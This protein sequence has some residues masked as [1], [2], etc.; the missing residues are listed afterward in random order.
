M[1]DLDLFEIMETMTLVLMSIN[2]KLEKIDMKYT[3][4]TTLII[5][6]TAIFFGSTARAMTM[7]HV[8]SVLSAP[9]VLYDEANNVIA[10]GE[11]KITISL[12]DD[13]HNELYAEEQII[14]VN[15]GL[16]QIT[17]GQGYATGSDLT[18]PAGGLSWDIF[19]TSGDISVEIAVEGQTNPQEITVLGSQPYSFIAERAL[20]VTDDSITSDKIKNGT[21]TEE[22]LDEGL[23]VKLS[24]GSS[25]STPSSTQTL[26]GSVVIDSKNVSVSSSIGLNNAS[27]S[28]V[29]EILQ[30]LDSS[31]DV[32][33]DTHL[34]QGMSSLEKKIGNLDSIYATDTELKNEVTKIDTTINNLDSIYATDI[35]LNNEVSNINEDL[36]N[37]LARIAFLEARP[38]FDESDIP[39][40][41]KPLAFGSFDNNKGQITNC[42]GFNI[43]SSITGKCQFNSNPPVDT[44]Y[45]VLMTPVGSYDCGS[46]GSGS[47]HSSLQIYSKTK[48]TSYF[49]AVVRCSN[50][51]GT[52]PTKVD[53]VVFYNRVTN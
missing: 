39:Q 46:G 50:A 52:N 31:L 18:S 29:F 5:L 20:S 43:D 16:A 41:N 8:P 14:T 25:S 33:R 24:G 40:A 17:I 38:V 36:N 35:N 13:N 37:I 47:L 27:G 42:S 19:S 53:F 7:S 45:S 32:L 4:I 28:N 12:L 26:S 21:I 6:F 44:E 48:T 34:E 3:H 1:I 22:D 49:D 2:S 9:V 10:D 30:G 51:Y 23:L 11:Y 15:K